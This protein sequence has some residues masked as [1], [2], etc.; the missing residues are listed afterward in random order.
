V[1]AGTDDE[2]PLETSVL[3][4]CLRVDRWLLSGSGLALAL[5]AKPHFKADTE[6]ENLGVVVVESRAIGLND[7][8]VTDKGADPKDA[9]FSERHRRGSGHGETGTV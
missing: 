4:L 3:S 8:E 1:S 9:R 6:T 7:L 5:D 2:K